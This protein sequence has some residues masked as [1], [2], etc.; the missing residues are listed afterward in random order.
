MHNFHIAADDTTQ[1][2]EEVIA[3]KPKNLANRKDDYWVMKPVAVKVKANTQCAE[4]SAPLH[5]VHNFPEEGS[6]PGPT[7][8]HHLFKKARC[9][10]KPLVQTSE[11]LSSKVNELKKTVALCS[12]MATFTPEAGDWWNGFFEDRA[13]MA[14]EQNELEDAPSDAHLVTRVT[15]LFWGTGHIQVGEKEAPLP[16][17]AVAAEENKRLSDLEALVTPRTD[18]VLASEWGRS[19]KVGYLRVKTSEATASTISASKREAMGR[20]AVDAAFDLEDYFQALQESD[21][22]SEVEFVKRIQ[23]FDNINLLLSSSY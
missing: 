6:I 8:K 10:N 5:L 16:V 21:R 1:A 9:K 22:G 2:G 12:K 7:G 17:V 19:R 18:T 11:E 14:T 15:S 23:V 13:G 3:F 20:T 4:W